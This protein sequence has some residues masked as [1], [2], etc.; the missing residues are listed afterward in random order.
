MRLFCI[1][2]LKSVSTELPDDVVFRAVAICPECIEQGY[3][4][5]SSII[6]EVVVIYEGEDACQQCLGWKRI[7]NS[8]DQES[9]KYWA[10]LPTQSAIAVQVGMVKPVE[11]P[12]CHGT[13][14]EP[15]DPEETGDDHMG[16][17]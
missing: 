12:R 11:C 5:P 7:A 8:D 14:V 17:L 2:C 3:R 4:L 1:N 13:G 16:K 10:E 6:N 9:W 15:K